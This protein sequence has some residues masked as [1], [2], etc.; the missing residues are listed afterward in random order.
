METYKK[1]GGGEIDDGDEIEEIEEF[2]DD[3]DEI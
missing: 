1:F 2:E 3:N